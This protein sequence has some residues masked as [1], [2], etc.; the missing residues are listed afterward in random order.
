MPET[1][2]KGNVL[3]T[4]ASGCRRAFDNR[5]LNFDEFYAANKSGRFH[6]SATPGEFEKEHSTTHCGAGDSSDRT[7]LDPDD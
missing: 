1:M 6:V 4:T 2:P 7:C 3:W 5:P